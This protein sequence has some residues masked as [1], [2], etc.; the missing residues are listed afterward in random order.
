MITDVAR[1]SGQNVVL[2]FVQ[3]AIVALVLC[4]LHICHLQS[5]VDD[6]DWSTVMELRHASIV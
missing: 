1:V 3:K 6:K 5:N 4:T 2:K